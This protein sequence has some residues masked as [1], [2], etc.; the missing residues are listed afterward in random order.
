MAK[1]A[2]IMI[3]LNKI[4]KGGLIRNE[5]L[6]LRGDIVLVLGLILYFT[7]MQWLLARDISEFWQ[8]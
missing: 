8:A 1:E 2:P 7:L 3:Q 6:E 5:N 4:M